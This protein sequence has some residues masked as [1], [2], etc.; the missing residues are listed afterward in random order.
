LICIFLYALLFAQNF[1]LE[2]KVG[3]TA[4]LFIGEVKGLITMP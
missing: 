3:V 1:I 4:G 2:K